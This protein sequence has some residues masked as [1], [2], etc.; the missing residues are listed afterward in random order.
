MTNVTD[1]GASVRLETSVMSLDAYKISF[2]YNGLADNPQLNVAVKVAATPAE[3]H[4]LVVAKELHKLE[5][6]EEW[7][8]MEAAPAE[9]LFGTLTAEEQ[10]HEGIKDFFRKKQRDMF[11]TLLD[12]SIELGLSTLT[13]IQYSMG[14][15]YQ[16]EPSKFK[17]D[18]QGLEAFWDKTRTEFEADMMRCKEIIARGDGEDDEATIE[19]KFNLE[20]LVATIKAGAHPKDE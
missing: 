14:I 10:R 4:D 12:K 11:A 13:Q 3:P 6:E 1:D 2:E 5:A 16:A 17:T 9:T 8:Y 19:Y 15:C 7:P 20:N 18:E